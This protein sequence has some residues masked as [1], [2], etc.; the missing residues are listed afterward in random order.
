ML[1]MVD[2]PR[3]RLA[4]NRFTGLVGCGALARRTVGAAKM[5]CLAARLSP[6]SIKQLMNRAT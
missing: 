1:A 5:L 3:R 2:L 6:R 4:A